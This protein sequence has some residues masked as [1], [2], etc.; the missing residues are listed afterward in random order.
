MLPAAHNAKAP[1]SRHKRGDVDVKLA[2]YMQWWKI[3]GRPMNCEDAG[4]NMIEIINSGYEFHYY[5][6]ILMK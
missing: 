1:L 3:H 6:V 2:E 4:C 5:Q